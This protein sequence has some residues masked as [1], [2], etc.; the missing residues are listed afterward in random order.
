MTQVEAK[1]AEKLRGLVLVIMNGP[2]EEAK[3]ELKE[4]VNRLAGVPASPKSNP[5]TLSNK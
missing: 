3:V 4:T 5:A 2:N 1:E